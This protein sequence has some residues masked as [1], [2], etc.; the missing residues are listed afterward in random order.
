MQ[1]SD[2]MA[3]GRCDDIQGTYQQ[4][5]HMSVVT[6]LVLSRLVFSND[7]CRELALKLCQTFTLCG[8][9]IAMCCL[10][11]WLSTNAADAKS[12]AA[13]NALR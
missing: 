7:R 4:S 6:Q 12:F 2:N 9:I 10:S 8:V 13:S 1:L 3:C 11:A 5:H